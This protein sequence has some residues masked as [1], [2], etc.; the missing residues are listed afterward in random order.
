MTASDPI[1]YR[2]Q[3]RSP[4]PYHPQEKNPWFEH[5]EAAFFLAERNGKPVGRISA[6]IDQLVL[7]H[8]GASI[9]QWG[10]F[11]AEDTEIATALLAQAEDWLRARGMTRSMGPFSL[12][13]WDEPGCSSK[14][15]IMPPR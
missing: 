11:E 13:I 12:S 2:R 6:Q 9:G 3:S 14:A 5:A 15:M 7:E 1:G 4:R 10:M 8:M